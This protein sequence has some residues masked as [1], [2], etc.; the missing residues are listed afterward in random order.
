MGVPSGS[1]VYSSISR[2]LESDN[3][4]ANF[5]GHFIMLIMLVWNLGC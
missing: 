1:T 3:M 2:Q 5:G 4:P